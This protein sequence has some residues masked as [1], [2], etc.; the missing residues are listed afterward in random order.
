MS[1][2]FLTINPQQLHAA[3]SRGQNATV[4]DVRSIAEYVNFSYALEP[5]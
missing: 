4:P 2:Q 1:M 5:Q 3:K